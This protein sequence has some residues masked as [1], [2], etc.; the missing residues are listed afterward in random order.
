MMSQNKGIEKGLVENDRLIDPPLS[1][2]YI[3]PILRL[4]YIF[5]QAS[6]NSYDLTELETER[7]GN[8]AGQVVD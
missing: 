6:H 2:L 8:E 7:P 3:W 5:Y 1:Y 4:K